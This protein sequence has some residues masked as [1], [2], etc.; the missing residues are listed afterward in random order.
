MRQ[1]DLAHLML[2]D[3]QNESIFKERLKPYP[4]GI[5]SEK[6]EFATKE[7]FSHLLTEKGS[8]LSNDQFTSTM[9][10]IQLSLLKAQVQPFS[11]SFVSSLLFFWLPISPLFIWRKVEKLS[12]L[13]HWQHTKQFSCY[14]SN[15][16]RK[17]S[18]YH[19]AKLFSL[20]ANVIPYY[21]RRLRCLPT[22]LEEVN[23]F[24][25]FFFDH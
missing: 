20:H 5:Q 12:Q 4:A 10:Q 18:G 1:F 24:H 6:P 9:K 2:V 13:T 23:S 3:P 7:F 17:I 15:H 25:S 16:E 11:F 19:F 21:T 22:H 8:S 14:D